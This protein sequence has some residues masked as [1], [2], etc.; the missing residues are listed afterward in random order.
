MKRNFSESATVVAHR[1]E[2]VAVYA[3]WGDGRPEDAMYRPDQ[4]FQG[5]PAGAASGRRAGAF[6]NGL[7][8]LRGAAAALFACVS[9]GFAGAAPAAADPGAAPAA[10][11]PTDPVADAGPPPPPV[12]D[13]HVASTPPVTAKFPDGWTLTVSAHD[14]TER[15]VPS[16][17]DQAGTREYIVGGVFNGSVHAP[18]GAGTPQG[19]FEVGYQTA[20]QVDTQPPANLTFGIGPNMASDLSL[21]GASIVTTVPVDKA[22]FKGT[23]PWV[24]VS[25][26][27][28]KI[29]GGVS[30]LSQLE[31]GCIGKSFIR[32]YATLTAST[33][34]SNVSQSYYGTIKAS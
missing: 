25:G 15:P 9:I 23:D 11:G 34:T 26:F 27:S 17:T 32:S 1:A 30:A 33:G 6:I 13:G 22:D 5:A 8:V 19:T 21:F 2:G 3:D 20:C 28:I 4:D 7:P 10:N 24:M 14:E 12:D 29:D 31:T 18:A 16:L